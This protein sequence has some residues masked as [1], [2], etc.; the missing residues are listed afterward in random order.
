MNEVEASFAQS[1][2]DEPLD[3]KSALR[4]QNSMVARNWPAVAVELDLFDR[5]LR[6][7]SAFEFYLESVAVL[8][9]RTSKIS[10]QVEADSIVQALLHGSWTALISAVHLALFGAH[11]D[12]VALIR[13][14]LE[15]AYHAEYFSTRPAEAVEWDSFGAIPDVRLFR[16]AFGAWTS[17][18]K[19]KKAVDRQ[20]N[21]PGG[22][23]QTFAELSTYG[24]HANPK[25]VGLRSISDMPRIVNAGFVSHGKVQFTKLCAS[26]ALH[27][28]VYVLGQYADFYAD[29]LKQN[30]DLAS[31]IDAFKQDF[32]DYGRLPFAPLSPLD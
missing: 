24:T 32:A 4:M 6:L 22:L 20:A 5:G 27:V 15:A 13:S 19:V 17:I 26:R 1:G 31:Q 2:V 8:A 14:A 30:S 9:S 18:K 16:K 21:P 25:T 29:H 10:P 28:L 7:V 11:V 12:S 3:L 23:D